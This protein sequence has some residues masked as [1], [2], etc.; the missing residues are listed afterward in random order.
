MDTKVCFKCGQEKPLSEFYKHKQMADGH[1]NKCKYCTKK[2]IKEREEVLRNDPEWVAKE[3]ARGREKYHRLGYKDKYKE[4]P[5]DA[6]ERTKNYRSKYPEKY[7]A[8]NSVQKIDCPKG[9]HKHHWSYNE[10]H[11]KDII[12]LSELDHNK[13]HRFCTY[14]QECKMYRTLEGNLLDTKEKHLKHFE[15]IKDLDSYAR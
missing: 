15:S 4:T 3:R 13:L 11:Y 6:Y 2:G 5:E 10:E 8:T 7:K 14:D 1:L 9:Y 12:I